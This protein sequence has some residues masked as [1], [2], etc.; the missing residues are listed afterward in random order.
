MSNQD[1]IQIK[2]EPRQAGKHYSRG[3]RVNK[4]IPAVIYGPHIENLNIIISELDANKYSQAKYENSIFVLNSADKKINK[5]QVLRK[6][7]D[8]HPVSRRPTHID[9]YALDINQSVRVHVEIHFVGKSKGVTEGGVL[10]VLRRDVEVECLPKDIP[11]FFEVDVTNLDVGHALHVSDM[12]H[13]EQK[14]KFITHA[15]EAIVTVAQTRAE[16]ETSTSAADANATPATT[17]KKD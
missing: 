6:S 1:T 2:A 9:F 12:T 17:E 15:E 8:R 7:M 10:Q 11:H 4:Q 16:E 13:D 14:I 5:L 3:H